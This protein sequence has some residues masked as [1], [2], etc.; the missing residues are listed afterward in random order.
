MRLL[1]QTPAPPAPPAA[2]LRASPSLPPLALPGARDQGPGETVRDPER[3]GE[4]PPPPPT[5]TPRDGEPELEGDRERQRE[6]DMQRD[7]ED[8]ERQ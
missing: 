5:H 8:L 1:G 7:A 6:K 4:T 2:R 3:Q